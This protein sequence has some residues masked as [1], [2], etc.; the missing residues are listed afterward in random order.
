MDARPAKQEERKTV[1]RLNSNTFDKVNKHK[2]DKLLIAN[3][4]DNFK[5]LGNSSSTVYDTIKLN[6]TEVIF[7]NAKS[8]TNH[9]PPT[10][11]MVSN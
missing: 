8:Q 9:F 4:I 1:F 10:I 7:D 5:D 11:G 6:Q 3:F 2:I